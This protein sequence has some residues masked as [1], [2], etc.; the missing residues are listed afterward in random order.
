[1][2][3]NFLPHSACAGKE[4]RVSVLELEG[5]FVDVWWHMFGCEQHCWCLQIPE[6]G[7]E[8]CK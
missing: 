5:V 3:L 7:M 6:R 2:K 1:M 4:F 8:S